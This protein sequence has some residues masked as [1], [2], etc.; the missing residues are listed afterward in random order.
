MPAKYHIESARY[1]IGIA[2][3]SIGWQWNEH[4]ALCLSFA[5]RHLA[6]ARIATR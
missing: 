2:R 6:E 1:W 3:Q 4:A 5:R